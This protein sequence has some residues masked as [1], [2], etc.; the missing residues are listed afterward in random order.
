M[1]ALARRAR[2]LSVTLTAV[3][4][5]VGSALLAAAVPHASASEPRATALVARSDAGQYQVP[6]GVTRVTVVLLGASGTARELCSPLGGPGW[7]VVNVQVT[8]FGG[9]SAAVAG[10]HFRYR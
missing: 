3:A 2:S 7:G 4:A 6:A 10:D 8:T 1:T 5:L 9:P